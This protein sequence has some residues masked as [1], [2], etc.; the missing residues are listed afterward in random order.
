MSVYKNR[1]N[2]FVC[3][4]AFVCLIKELNLHI[5]TY[6]YI[7]V[8]AYVYKAK[9]YIKHSCRFIVVIVVVVIVD[10]SKNKCQ[11]KQKNVLE[12]LFLATLWLI[13][14]CI[15]FLDVKNYGISLKFLNGV[16]INKLYETKVQFIEEKKN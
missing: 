3:M 11:K 13:N 8:Y 14:I 7:F 6:I 9:L 5:H 16:V 15:L 1:V 2:V 10:F 12:N 4:H